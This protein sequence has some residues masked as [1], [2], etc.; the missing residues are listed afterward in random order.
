MA[1][2]SLSKVDRVGWAG[3]WAAVFL[4]GCTPS[5]ARTSR[6]LYQSD[7]LVVSSSPMLEDD[8]SPETRS[9][10]AR[11]TYSFLVRNAAQQRVSLGL[12]G[13]VFILRGRAGSA[14]CS[15]EGMKLDVLWLV[16][17]DFYRIDCIL[18]VGKD[19]LAGLPRR[20]EALGELHIQL[21]APAGDRQLTFVY[22][23]RAGDA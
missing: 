4:G 21:H 1:V 16:P 9:D 23:F 13:A 10:A 12:A 11:V 17:R 5:S 14:D 7:G 20:G 8:A 6:V 2:A 19:Q 18:Q 3:L 22:Q 15:T